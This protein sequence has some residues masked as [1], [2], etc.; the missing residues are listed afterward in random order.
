MPQ[1]AKFFLKR[2]VADFSKN[3]DLGTQIICLLFSIWTIFGKSAFF[4]KSLLSLKGCPCSGHPLLYRLSLLNFS[5]NFFFYC[6]FR[7]VIRAIYQYCPKALL[8]VIPTFPAKGIVANSPSLVQKQRPFLFEL[9][10]HS[11]HNINLFSAKIKQHDR[12]HN[13]S[14]CKKSAPMERITDILLY[15]I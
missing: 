7:A 3:G 14:C 4:I 1:Q 10:R 2:R 13:L 11:R 9:F 5:I 15:Q 8:A 6:S 12:L